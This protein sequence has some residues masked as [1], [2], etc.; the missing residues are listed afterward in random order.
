MNELLAIE[1]GIIERCAAVGRE[2]ATAMARGTLRQSH[3]D[4]ASAVG[5]FA[6]LRSGGR[7]GFGALSLR[8]DR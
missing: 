2:T 5:G 7:T 8:A 3:G 4:V 1:G 6:G